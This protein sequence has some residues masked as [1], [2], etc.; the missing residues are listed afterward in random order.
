MYAGEVVVL[1]VV[2][3]L[4]L[5]PWLALRSVFRQPAARWEATGHSRGAWVAVILLVPVLGAALYLRR[6]RPRLRAV[7][8]G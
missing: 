1:F 4:V 3:A 2:A 8:L 6:V 7:E 5:L